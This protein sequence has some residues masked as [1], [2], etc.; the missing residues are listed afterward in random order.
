MKKEVKCDIDELV[1]Y[2]KFL[3]NDWKVPQKL[4]THSKLY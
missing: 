2:I 3:L 4:D 1:E